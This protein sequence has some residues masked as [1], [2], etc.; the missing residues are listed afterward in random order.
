M[1]YVKV[2]EFENDEPVEVPVE[3]SGDCILLST[4]TSQFP[5]ATGLKFRTDDYVWRG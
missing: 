2:A 1:F 5:G 3:A 4:L